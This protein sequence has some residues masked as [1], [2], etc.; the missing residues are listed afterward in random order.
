M[1]TGCVA[2]FGM[3]MMALLPTINTEEHGRNIEEEHRTPPGLVIARCDGGGI[4]RFGDL[5][6]QKNKTL[7]GW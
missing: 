6:S 7:L 1:N 5:F 4:R 3:K 2:C